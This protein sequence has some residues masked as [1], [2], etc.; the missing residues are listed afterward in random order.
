[1]IGILFA[2][3]ANNWNENKKNKKVEYQALIDLR[4]EF[5]RVQFIRRTALV[6]LQGSM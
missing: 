2:L 6:D 4:Q 5:N 3:Q 1:M